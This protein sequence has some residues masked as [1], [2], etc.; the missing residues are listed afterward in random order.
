[1][2]FKSSAKPTAT[3]TGSAPTKTMPEAKYQWSASILANY[4]KVALVCVC[5]LIVYIAYRSIPSPNRELLK[6]AEQGDAGAQY[7][8]GL[9]YYLG[10]GVGKDH[11]QALEW[12]LKSA[13]Q[14]DI[15]SQHY[16]GRMYYLGQ[17]SKK[18]YSQAFEWFRK[19]AEQGNPR[20]QYS[21]SIMYEQGQGVE[22]SNYQAFVWLYKAAEQGDP[23]AQFYLG[24]KYL[25]RGDLDQASRWMDEAHDQGYQL[26]KP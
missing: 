15:K 23:E 11:A 26:P 6:A 19:A 22:R 13:K 21:L 8:I 18:D 5:L 4:K 7:K 20:A 3:F 16:L 17:G 9:V 1:M 25:K 14:G 12:F 24:L 2:N 10:E